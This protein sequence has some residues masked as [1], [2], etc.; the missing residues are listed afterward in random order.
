MSGRAAREPV[1]EPLGQRPAPVPQVR[2]RIW[3]LLWES[4]LLNLAAVAK[5]D[6]SSLFVSPIFY[7]VAPMLALLVTVL[8]YLPPLA[9]GQPF[10]MGDLL[11][12]LETLMVFFVPVLTM[13][14]LAE[15]RRLGTLEVLLT[16]PVRDW[17]VVVG[18]WLGGLLAYL[19]AVSFTLVYVLLLSIQEPLR[20]QVDL[21]GM[22]LVLPALDYGSILVAYVGLVLVGAAWV[23]VGVLASSL[24]SNQVVAAVVGI[25]TLL[26]VDVGL[27]FAVDLPLPPA[28]RDFLDYASASR[29]AFSFQDGRLVLSDAVYYLTLVVG[30]LFLA[31]RVLESRRWR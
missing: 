27:A 7:V 30:A 1:T 12:L 22:R 11:N 10:T 29:H 6:L 14:L 15:E 2:D 8:G 3:G 23:A 31:T 28:L 16:S 21:A 9:N 20:T 13:R 26:L 4:G 19:A 17:E 24:T 25:F 18:K 5:R